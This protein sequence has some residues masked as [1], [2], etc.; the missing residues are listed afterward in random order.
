VEGSYSSPG[1]GGMIARSLGRIRGELEVFLLLSL[2]L[3][4]S[5]TLIGWP[6]LTET[7][8]LQS[9]P[10]GDNA[11]VLGALGN[12]LP[13]ALGLMAAMLVVYATLYVAWIRTGL[14]GRSHAFESGFLK[15]LGMVLWR[16]VALF[17]YGFLAAIGIVIV[18]SVLQAMAGILGGENGSGIVQLFTILAVIAC[19]VPITLAYYLAVVGTA[20]DERM[21]IH[22]AFKA[23]QGLWW[24]VIGASLIGFM[25][26]IVP[27]IATSLATGMQSG[28]PNL[29]WTGVSNLIGSFANLYLITLAMTAWEAIA[30]RGDSFEKD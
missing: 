3:A 5:A 25:V 11:A 15:R 21:P 26:L 12:F 23:L 1:V 10:P 8:R 2:L 9:V 28:E 13:L 20:L 17:G 4:V 29:V 24:P 6:M 30:A 16:T 14:L 22:R 19:F 7:A 27:S 18:S